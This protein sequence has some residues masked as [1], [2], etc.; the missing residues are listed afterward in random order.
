MN[1]I[2]ML[3]ELVKELRGEVK[4]LQRQLN[5]TQ[6]DY[7]DLWSDVSRLERAADEKKAKK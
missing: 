7:S 4:E 3:W 6:N 2:D 5:A 1:K